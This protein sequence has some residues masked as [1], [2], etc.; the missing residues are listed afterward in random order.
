MFVSLLSDWLVNPI[1]SLE[2]SAQIQR[3]NRRPIL[4]EHFFHFVN[5]K[6]DFIVLAVFSIDHD[7]ELVVS[8][9]KL[10]FSDYFCNQFNRA[11][12]LV[13]TLSF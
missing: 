12:S 9:R 6:P 8:L 11:L 2:Y 13:Y 10:I 3:A 7:I 4:I 1:T 5:N